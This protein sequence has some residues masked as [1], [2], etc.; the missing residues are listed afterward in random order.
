[1]KIH[2]FSLLIL[3]NVWLFFL[4]MPLMRQLHKL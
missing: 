1:M 2:M 4:S 3:R